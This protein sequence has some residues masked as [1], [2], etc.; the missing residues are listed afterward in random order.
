MPKPRQ[1]RVQYSE[2]IHELIV[3]NLR[4][5]GFLSRAADLAGVNPNVVR[6][7]ME[8]G[9]AGIEPYA[10][11][12]ADCRKAQSEKVAMLV[13]MTGAEPGGPR[14]LLT[15]MDQATFGEKS[16]QSAAEALIEWLEPRVSPSAFMEVINALADKSGLGRMA[17]EEDE[18]SSVIDVESEAVE[19]RRLSDGDDPD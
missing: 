3:S 6:W 12:V 18:G 1:S 13:A 8:K 9:R 11:F 2:A 4:S 14:W 16:Q 5:V 15:K 10:A 17:D 7:W 19:P